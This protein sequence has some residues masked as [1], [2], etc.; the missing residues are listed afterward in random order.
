MKP[1]VLGIIPAR[2][3]SSRLPNKPL[4][5][6]K[7]KPIIQHVWERAVK[8]GLLTDLV[9]ATEDM[10]VY[11]R[12]VAFGGKAM[13]TSQ[14]H[15]TGT[16]R[17][18]EVQKLMPGFDFYLNIQG[19]EPFLELGQI[20]EIHRAVSLGYPV[21]TLVRK[22]QSLEDLRNISFVKVVKS[23][24]N[25]ILYISRLPIPGSKSGFF[26]FEEHDFW[27]GVG[28]YLFSNAALKQIAKMKLSSLWALEDIEQLKWLEHDLPLY[29]IETQF[30]TLA[31]DTPEDLAKAERL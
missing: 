17:C 18:T 1:T 10:A 5:L 14:N 31:I 30:N 22:I 7:G 13:L 24:S 3:K 23:I 8:S 20:E 2:L 6:L 29:A 25:R 26:N 12:V 9:V 28:L 4:Q 15:Q 19:D 27:H 11:D 21:A 16:D